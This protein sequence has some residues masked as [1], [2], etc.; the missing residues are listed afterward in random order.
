L[1]HQ[2]LL[3]KAVKV[4]K[5][6]YLTTCSP[7]H[8]R[9]LPAQSNEISSHFF[10][11]IKQ[12][13]YE[14]R[15]LKFCMIPHGIQDRGKSGL[16]TDSATA[17]FGTIRLFLSLDVLLKLRISFIDISGAY[18]QAASLTRDILSAL[19]PDGH[20]LVFYGK[21]F[22]PHTVLLEA[23]VYGNLQLNVGLQTTVS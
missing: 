17:L 16:R 20:H 21:F 6:N 18:L 7:V 15:K 5:S 4:E 14:H 2:W 23:V 12:S 8:F 10:F 13:S 3:D 19:L 9:D 11:S 22:V 1:V